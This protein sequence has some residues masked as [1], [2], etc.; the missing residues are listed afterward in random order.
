V[1]IPP[2]LTRISLIGI[3]VYVVICAVA[4]MMQRKLLYFPD[5]S[6][7]APEGRMQD[8]TLRTSDDVRIKGTW[9]AGSR[10][11]AIVLFHGNAGNRGD[12]FDW[13]RPFIS[14]GWGVFLVDYR[15]YGGSDGSPSEDGLNCD[16]DAVV[17]W[18]AEHHPKKRLVYFGESIGCGVALACAMRHAPAGL[19]LQSA[20]L[21]L[22]DVAGLHYPILPTSLIMLDRFNA[23][24][25]ASKLDA[26]LL[27]IH[28]TADSIIPMR[29][30]L[31]VYDVYSGPKQ[32]YQIEGAGHNDVPWVGGRD[33]YERIHRFL[34]SIG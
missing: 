2:A 28:G 14:L 15:G 27:S 10:D 23:K 7:V 21:D 18:M 11:L 5:A 30:G 24:G 16:A 31:A 26:P 4:C 12:R 8:V 32:W 6:P 34:E 29:L 3:G 25:K 20:T 9:W 13:M 22:A 33:Y 17:E 19:V 1:T